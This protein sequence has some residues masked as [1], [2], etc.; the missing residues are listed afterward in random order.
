[1]KKI[2]D[3]KVNQWNKKLISKKESI[4]IERTLL[5]WRKKKERTSFRNE[6]EELTT[7][8]TDIKR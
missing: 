3:N 4:K 1:M 5:W 7:D 6:N 2:I 8:P